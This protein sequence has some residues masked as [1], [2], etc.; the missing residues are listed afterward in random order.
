MQRKTID[1]IEANPHYQE[2]VRSRKRFAW[3]LTLLMLAIYYG[4]I[5]TIAFAPEL[6]AVPVAEGAITTVG[7][8]LGILI[9]LSAFL[10]TGLYVARANGRFD[11]LT[12]T[13]QEE[14]R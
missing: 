13:I 4:F 14:A 10:L 1:A 2:L 7:M 5:L 9:I 12:K 3:V 11:R 8:P 6:L